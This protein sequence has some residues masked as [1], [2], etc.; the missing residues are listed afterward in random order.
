MRHNKIQGVENVIKEN[1][2]QYCRGG[3]AGQ[4]NYA[5]QNFRG[6]KREKRKC[7]TKLQGWKMREK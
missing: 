1:A 4:E 5:A 3:N 6:G 2:A 7:S